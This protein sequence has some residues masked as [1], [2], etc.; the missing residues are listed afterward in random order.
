MS[1][2]EQTDESERISREVIADIVRD[3]LQIAFDFTLIL[4]TV[5]S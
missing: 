3:T 1:M 2:I 4:D 5:Q